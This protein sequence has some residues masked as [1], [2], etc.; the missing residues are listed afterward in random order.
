MYY[1]CGVSCPLTI[2]FEKIVVF[3]EFRN[4]G[5]DLLS[6]LRQDALC[7]KSN[8]FGISITLTP[9]L[10][11]K[12]IVC[13]EVRVHMDIY[14]RT[15][16]FLEAIPNKILATKNNLESAS[17]LLPMERIGY[18]L[19]VLIFQLLEDA[20]EILTNVNKHLIF[21]ILSRTRVNLPLIIFNF[22]R[23]KIIASHE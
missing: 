23:K 9:A 5:L 4:H 1:V 17:S 15:S 8:I 16:P 7:I 14:P 6:R 11:V 10:I 13:E 3:N 20:L 2:A 12:A 18:Q 19:L 21:F 22:L